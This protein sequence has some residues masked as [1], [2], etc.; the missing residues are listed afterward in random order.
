MEFLYHRHVQGMVMGMVAV[1]SDALVQFDH[2]ALCFDA[3]RQ[4]KFTVGIQQVNL[5]D[6][7]QI[8][9]NRIFREFQGDGGIFQNFQRIFQRNFYP[10][11]ARVSQNLLI[12]L[13]LIQNLFIVYGWLFHIR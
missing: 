6:F 5:S 8:K 13:L 4:A 11:F 10:I 9:A 3:R 1:A 12:R 2:A 7:F